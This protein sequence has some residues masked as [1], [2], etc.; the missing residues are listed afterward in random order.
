VPPLVCWSAPVKRDLLD[1][2][3]KIDEF[4][5]AGTRFVWVVRLVGRRRVDVYE[6]GKAMRTV[7]AGG[8]A[9]SARRAE[10]RRAGR[11]AL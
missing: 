11:R 1:F 8:S 6:R 2:N 3:K 5:A 9:R 7:Y 10:E 4:L